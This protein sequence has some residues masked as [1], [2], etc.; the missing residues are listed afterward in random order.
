M[1]YTL[2]VGENCTQCANVINYLV[3]N[4]ISYKTINV[5]LDSEKPPISIYAYPAL[6]EGQNLL[7][8]G[9]DIISYLKDIYQ[10]G[11]N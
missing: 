5:D 6:F 8:Y 10:L 7:R 11:N 9:T 3:E 4:N 2:Y 1:K